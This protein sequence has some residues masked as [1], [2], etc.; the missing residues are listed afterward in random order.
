MKPEI[1]LASVILP[2]YNGN[3]FLHDAINSI[4]NQSHTN[5]ELLIVDD[6]STDNSK[7]IIEEFA[8]KDNRIRF[9]MQKNGG[10]AAARNVALRAASGEYIGFIDQ[11]DIWHLDKLEI[12]IAY[13]EKSPDA[14]FVHGNID[15]IDDQLVPVDKNLYPWDTDASG[16]CFAR[17]FRQNAIAIQTVCLKRKCLETVGLLREDVPGVDDYEYWLRVSRF[18]SI[19]YID[20]TFALYR[21]HGENESHKWH[22]QDI[23][24]SMVLEGILAQFPD[25]YSELGTSNVNK[26]MAELYREIADEFIRQNNYASARPYLIKA[27]KTS[28]FRPDTLFKL[29]ISEIPSGI[30]SSIRWYLHKF[31]P[32]IK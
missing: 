19:E 32:F 17:L 22:S 5:L 11:D 26:Q 25:I 3:K 28:L 23:K 24:R 9:F 30:R 10:V 4:L 18:F 7:D 12:Q 27:L 16:R 31:N 21:F 14:V 29:I 6:G 20:N 13:L 2:V 1:Q 8:E 15:Y